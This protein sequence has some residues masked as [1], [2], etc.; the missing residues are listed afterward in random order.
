MAHLID[1]CHL[2][3][4]FWVAPTPHLFYKCFGRFAPRIL[5]VSAGW[6]LAAALVLVYATPTC[7][8]DGVYCYGLDPHSRC[9]NHNSAVGAVEAPRAADA[10]DDDRLD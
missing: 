4:D 2:G 6:R 5:R 10:V 8:D 7:S 1:K 3:A 9:G